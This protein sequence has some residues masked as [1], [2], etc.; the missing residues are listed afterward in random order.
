MPDMQDKVKTDKGLAVVV[1]INVIG[2][3]VKVKYIE[4]SGYEWL[5]IDNISKVEA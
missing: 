3:K 1:D 4:D 5:S 2:Q